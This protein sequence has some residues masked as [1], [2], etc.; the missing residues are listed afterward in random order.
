MTVTI[1]GSP[2]ATSTS[3]YWLVGTKSS[4]VKGGPSKIIESITQ[5]SGYD[6]TTDLGPITQNVTQLGV[7]IEKAIVGLPTGIAAESSYNIPG[8]GTFNIKGPGG[9]AGTLDQAATTTGNA[10]SVAQL[11]TSSG[12]WKG[13][14]MCIAGGILVLLGLLQLSGRS[15]KSVAP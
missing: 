12:T 1:P 7:K 5:P 14:A 4:L 3:H 8:L 13:V 10:I 11:F 9:I 6:Y 15:V 2:P